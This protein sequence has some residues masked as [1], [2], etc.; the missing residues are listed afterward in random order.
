MAAPS[1]AATSAPAVIHTVHVRAE[2]SLQFEEV[3]ARG[4]M[5]DR[6]RLD[7]AGGWLERPDAHP[8]RGIQGCQ[9]S[10]TWRPDP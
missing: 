9:E 1:T 7:G 8:G 5:T 4:W 6:T 2:F 3:D 10:G